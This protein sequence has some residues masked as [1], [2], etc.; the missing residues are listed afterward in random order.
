MLASGI[1]P[2]QGWGESQCPL[3]GRGAG[4]KRGTFTGTGQRGGRREAEKFGEISVT[5]KAKLRAWK[6][7]SMALA[8]GGDGGLRRGNPWADQLEL[9]R[10]LPQGGTMASSGTVVRRLKA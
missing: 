4:G 6:A 8:E 5:S 3:P 2:L 10:G 1:S 9:T 7:A